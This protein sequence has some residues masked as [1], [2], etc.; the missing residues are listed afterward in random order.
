M[1]KLFVSVLGH[2]NSGKTTTWNS[3]FNGTVKTGKYKR[4]LLLWNNESV[5]VFLVNG[6]PQERNEKIEDL[7]TDDS[8]IVLCSIQYTMDAFQTYKYFLEKGYDLFVQWL[9][10]GYEDDTSFQYFDYIGLG[11]Y[12]LANKATI[13]MRSG[14]DNTEDRVAEIKSFIFGWATKNQLLSKT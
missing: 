14:K 7:L 10:P 3:L 13:S 11:N 6:S 4:T 9:N 1:N 12:L 2:R 8:A 5:D